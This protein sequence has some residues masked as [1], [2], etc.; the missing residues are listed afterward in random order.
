VTTAAAPLLEKGR[1]HKKKK[2]KPHREQSFSLESA[3]S[4]PSPSGAPKQ[5]LSVTGGLSMIR[6]ANKVDKSKSREV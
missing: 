3:A 5:L 1:S 4:S 6:R 2:K